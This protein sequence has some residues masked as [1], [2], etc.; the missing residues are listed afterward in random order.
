MQG[1]AAT[2]S[3]TRR[4]KSVTRPSSSVGTNFI[5]EASRGVN[6]RWGFAHLPRPAVRTCVRARQP[7]TSAG[8]A[9]RMRSV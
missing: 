3:T 9:A 7:A 5:Y 2:L 6:A 4:R 1:E 8:G